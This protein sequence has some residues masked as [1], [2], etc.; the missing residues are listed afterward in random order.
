MDTAIDC[1][2]LGTRRQFEDY[3]ATI[4]NVTSG[5]VSTIAQC[6]AE[7]CAA[8]WG[9][10]NP[11]ISGIGMAIGYVL[12]VALAVCIILIFY[13]LDSRPRTTRVKWLKAL[14]LSAA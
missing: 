8:L 7:V 5:N 6:K 1:N 11:D 4:R 10:G 12:E 2:L 9:S 14:A 3:F 13:I